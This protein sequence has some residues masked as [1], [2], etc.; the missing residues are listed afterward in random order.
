MQGCQVEA[1]K[2][3]ATTV[4]EAEL[5][6]QV[7][8]LTGHPQ[9]HESLEAFVAKVEASGEDKKHE[10]VEPVLD[11]ISEGEMAAAIRTLRGMGYYWNGGEQ[12]RPTVGKK[13]DFEQIDALRD[14]YAAEAVK[15]E[16]ER[17]PDTAPMY[18]ALQDAYVVLCGYNSNP[19]WRSFASDHAA[20]QIAAILHAVP[21]KKK[22]PK[23]CKNAPG[24]Y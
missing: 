24:G 17:K 9:E 19:A 13:P 16:R 10:A 22:Y 3:Y 20:R 5:D 15:Q 18:K 7:A 2:L 4:T 8:E 6:R 21:E 23:I 12:W 11:D 1:G 14:A